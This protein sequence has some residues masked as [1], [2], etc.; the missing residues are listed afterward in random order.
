MAI[1]IKA[2][3]KTEVKPIGEHVFNSFSNFF[4]DKNN[5]FCNTLYGLGVFF[6]KKN[7]EAV[8][9]IFS[10]ASELVFYTRAITT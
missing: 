5:G 7:S 2:K 6:H 9:N 10:T 1:T 8:G 4:G 3:V